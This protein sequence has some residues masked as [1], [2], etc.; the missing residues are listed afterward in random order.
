MTTPDVRQA[1][2]PS[3][4]PVAAALLVFGILALVWPDSCVLASSDKAVVLPGAQSGTV[5][6][7]HQSSFDIDGRSY[8]LAQ[9]VEILDPNGAQLDARAI[10]VLVEVKYLVKK[11]EPSKIIKMVLN[12]PR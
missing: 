6:A 1:S 3:Y 10:R 4:R 2:K 7:V 11:D 9:D 5:T 8:Q 12:L